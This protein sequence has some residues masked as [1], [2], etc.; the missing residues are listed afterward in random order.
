VVAVHGRKEANRTAPATLLP[1]SS[2][3]EQ[4]VAA[5]VAKLQQRVDGALG[6]VL[7]FTVCGVAACHEP[8]MW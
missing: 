5:T 3:S 6:W 2:Y 1:A 8:G 7:A 4:E